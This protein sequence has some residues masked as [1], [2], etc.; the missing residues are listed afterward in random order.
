MRMWHHCWRRQ[1]LGWVHCTDWEWN[2]GIEYPHR[3]LGLCCGY[4]PARVVGLC[5][6]Y[7]QSK[8]LR[9]SDLHNARSTILNPFNNIL[10]WQCIFWNVVTVFIDLSNPNV[11]NWRNL[12]EIL[13]VCGKVTSLHSVPLSFGPGSVYIQEDNALLMLCIR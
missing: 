2:L 8:I 10:K 4:V 1:W 7:D 5:R 6:V 13:F 12:L 3:Q 9:A 11:N